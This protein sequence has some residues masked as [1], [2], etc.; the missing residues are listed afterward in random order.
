MDTTITMEVESFIEKKENDQIQVIIEI[1]ILE[2]G[3]VDV[4]KECTIDPKLS[5]ILVINSDITQMSAIIKRLVKQH[6]MHKL[7]K[8]NMHF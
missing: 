4:V 1:L 5:V 8:M 7:G 2:V 6:I 3:V